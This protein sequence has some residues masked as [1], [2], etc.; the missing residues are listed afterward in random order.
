MGREPAFD[1]VL[2]MGVAVLAWRLRREN[3]V[4]TATILFIPAIM[5]TFLLLQRA[6]VVEAAGAWGAP[7][8]LAGVLAGLVVATRSWVRV[9]PSTG[10]IIVRGTL[11]SLLLWPGTIAC[12]LLGLC[13]PFTPSSVFFWWSSRKSSQSN[14]GRS[15]RPAQVYL[16]HLFQVA[17]VGY[18]NRCSLRGNTPSAH[19]VILA[20]HSDVRFIY[21]CGTRLSRR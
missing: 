8:A 20:A 4:S 9:E 16:F 17:G 10:A 12:Y 6:F 11:V 3:R 21:A 18:S 5:L 2:I 15:K 7:A 14:V 13:W 19:N 1:V